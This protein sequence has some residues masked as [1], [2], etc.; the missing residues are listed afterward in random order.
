MVLITCPCGR[1]VTLRSLPERPFVQCPQCSRRL[2]VMVDPTEFMD[3]CPK[4][5][6]YL[7]KD[8]M[9]IHVTVC[10]GEPAAVSE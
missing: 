6:R 7:E 5:G 1:D 9:P 4:C 8:V 2:P 10:T 3:R